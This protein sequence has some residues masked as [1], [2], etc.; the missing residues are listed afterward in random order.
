MDNGHQKEISLTSPYTK[1]QSNRISNLAKSAML[2]SLTVGSGFAL[3]MVPNI[4]L[5][6][7]I[8]FISG[9]ILGP[10]LGLQVGMASEFIFSIM[11]P[12]GSGLVF[13]FLLIAQVISMGL[14][15]LTGGILRNRFLKCNWSISKIVFL[16][17]TGF[18]LT[19]IFDSLTTI[20]YPMSVGFE[21]KEVL[22]V[23]I[24]GMGFTLVHQIGNTCLFALA[25]PKVLTRISDEV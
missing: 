10:W 25:L 4:E 19:F 3:L 7:T 1:N 8:I 17:F 5:M 22:A 24:A 12:L 6:T 13:P 20:S 23:Y 11:N 2:I 9:V 14:V 21:W 16:G 15:G 18:L